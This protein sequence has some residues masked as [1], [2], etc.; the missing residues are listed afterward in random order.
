MVCF[1]SFD[2]GAVVVPLRGLNRYEKSRLFWR[3][4]C[5]VDS[6]LYSSVDG[7]KIRFISLYFA[8]VGIL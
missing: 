4:V 8:L 7:L 6:V 5:V 1:Y 2:C 3:L